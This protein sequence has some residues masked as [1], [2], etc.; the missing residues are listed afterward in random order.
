MEGHWVVSMSASDVAPRPSF[1]T[2]TAPPALGIDMTLTANQRGNLFYLDL[3]NKDEQ[4]N[5]K[6][7]AV[8]R[9]VL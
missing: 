1:A 3:A 2:W 4:Q 6:I 5:M 7:V 8:K 9:Q